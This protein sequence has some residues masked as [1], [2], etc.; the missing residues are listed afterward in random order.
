[1]RMVA[2]ILAVLAILAAAGAGRAGQKVLTGVP[3]YRAESLGPDHPK[4]PMKQPDRLAAASLGAAAEKPILQD[5]PIG[6]VPEYVWWYGC[7]PTAGGMMVG[8]WDGQPGRG[9][10]YDGDAGVW[11]GNGNAGTRSMVAGTAHI[12]AG[13]E[14]GYT[15]GDWHNSASYPNHEANPDSIADF[16][17][18]VDGGSYG[19]DIRAG[20]EAYCEWDNP[21]TTV[22]ES[23]PATATLTEVAYYG[24]SFDYQDFKGEINAGRPV[25]LDIM[26][27]D[28]YDWLG[29]SVVAYG[30][31]DDM[32][33]VRVPLPTGDYVDL[34]V[35][36]FAVMDTWANGTGQSE[37]VDWNWNV[38]SPVIEGDGI[39]W[40]PF[41]ELLGSSWYYVDGTPGPYDW[42]VLEGIALEV[43]P[44]PATV[45]LAALGVLGLAARRRL[46]RAIG[47]R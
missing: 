22:N 2:A 32:F 26:C 19:N 1:M 36:G 35:G 33:Q 12:T 38:F 24:G 29:H 17:K 40:W 42:M 3:E 39:E 34:T 5:N 8:F 16:M 45:A 43:A 21:A 47:P 11:S 13:Y 27:F 25:L 18:T 30:Y 37:W 7:S 20:L 46:A 41:V 23:Y 14:N 44:E 6:G 10:L 31:R 28:G 4:P 15:Y 9:N